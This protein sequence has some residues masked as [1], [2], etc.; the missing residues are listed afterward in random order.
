MNILVIDG[1]GGKM[2]RRIVEE[3]CARY[4]SAE[5]TA[6]GTNSTATENMLKGGAVHAATGENPVRVAARR[7]DIIIGPIGIVIADSLYGEVTPAMARAV[8]QSRARRILLPVNKCDNLIA[9]VRDCSVNELVLDA[10]RMI[11]EMAVS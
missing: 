11:D 10:M 2:G 7:A 8:A 3:L 4:E 6:V 1:Q 5:I 9:G